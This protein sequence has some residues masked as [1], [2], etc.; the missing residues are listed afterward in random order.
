MNDT[1]FIHSK[2]IQ[3][4]PTLLCNLQCSHCYSSSGPQIRESISAELLKRRLSQLRKE[5]FNVVSFSGGEPLVYES[6][7]T[8][9]EYAKALGFRTTMISNGALINGKRAT[10]ISQLFD[11][12]GVSL[13]GDRQ[14]HDAMRGKGSFARA[15]KGIA[16]LRGK[17][18][19]FGVAHCVTKESLGLLPAMLEL[20][21]ELGASLF[22]L[23]PLVT[24]GRAG[25]IADDHAL[26]D[27]DLARLY[28][29]AELFRIQV[30]DRLQ[31][32]LDVAPTYT[33]AGHVRKF[34]IMQPRR[35]AFSQL[36]DIVNPV[37]VDQRGALWPVA[38]GMAKVQ[39]ISSAQAQCWDEELNE[40]R[41]SGFIKLK[42]LMSTALMALEQQG[43]LFVDWYGHMVFVSRGSIP[44][45]AV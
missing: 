1:G 15:L 44:L 37:I 14:L 8:V 22:Q 13:D 35:A 7:F 38:Y 3:V 40:Y 17:G 31:I 12:V 16:V 10:Q 21:L 9:A 4:H 33:V 39:M 19:T 27:E 6:L 43:N 32:Q 11:L 23:H 28:L 5:G 20:C 25:E 36:S 18:M 42:R 26:T 29:M 41:R 45:A 24:I 30:G 2:V 34:R